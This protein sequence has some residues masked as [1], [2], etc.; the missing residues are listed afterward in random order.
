MGGERKKGKACL[1]NYTVKDIMGSED[2]YFHCVPD[3]NN[4][5]SL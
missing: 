2:S 5:V 3:M 4:A 1:K